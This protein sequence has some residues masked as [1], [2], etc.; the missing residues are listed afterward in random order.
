MADRVPRTRAADL[1]DALEDGRFL[2][3]YQPQF[4]L[5]DGHVAGIEALARWDHPEGGLV[6]AGAFITDVENEGLSRRLFEM[7]LGD[8]CRQ[9]LAWA[10][11]SLPDGFKVWINVSG[12]QLADG[13]LPGDLAA[14]LEVGGTSPDL[15]GVEIT[16]TALL[17]DGDDSVEALRQV[18][19]MGI[20]LAIDDFGTGY[21]S[22]SW[23][24]RFPIDM[25]KIDRSFVS[26]LGHDP[27]DDAIVAAVIGLAHGLG[28]RVV[29][30]GVETHRQLAELRARRCD[31]A[32]GF[33]LARPASALAVSSALDPVSS[34]ADPMLDGADV[35]GSLR[36]VAAAASAD[37][38]FVLRD[39]GDGHL[40]NVGGVGRGE[41]WAGTVQAD[42]HDEPLIHE[43]MQRTEIIRVE[44]LTR[45]FGPYWTEAAA[46]TTVG[47]YLVILGGGDI[48]NAPDDVVLGAAAGAG[49][50]SGQVPTE[51]RLA[52]ERELTQ[53]ALSVAR[54]RPPSLSEAAQTL[55]E[56]AGS[57]LS[58]EFA[59]VLLDGPP[60]TL[61]L[62]PSGWRPEASDDDIIEALR[63]FRDAVTSELLVEQDTSESPHATRPLAFADGLLARVAIPLGEGGNLGVL[64]A[65]HT[66]AAPR[67]FTM[68]CRRVAEAIGEQGTTVLSSVLEE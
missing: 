37:D 41:G 64:V 13:S 18:R 32:Q 10:D 45:V 52:D 36:R 30:E 54:L 25:V 9:A 44:S 56:L 21:S 11:K 34:A 67:G 12:R 59:A 63:E 50:S 19:E 14:G 57:A 8:A 38:L 61:H 3:H 2:L 51:K 1:V 29:A 17:E 46:L 60:P 22:L 33:L 7:V 42:P 5:A 16:E 39:A 62:A 68:L 26:G 24:K 48:A 47:P 23:L 6:V 15:I 43:A 55:A 4:D 28:V 20:E 27:G 31:C 35:E 65:A 40:L 49:W 58:C 53:V 66:T